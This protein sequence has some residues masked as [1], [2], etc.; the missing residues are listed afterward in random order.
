[1][2]ETFSNYVLLAPLSITGPSSSRQ[3]AAQLLMRQ[4]CEGLIPWAAVG[5]ADAGARGPLAQRMGLVAMEIRAAV[6]ERLLVNYE[7]R[8]LLISYKDEL[9]AVDQALA[10]AS[11]QVDLCLQQQDIMLQFDNPSDEQQCQLHGSY[12]QMKV[13]M[14]QRMM[15]QHRRAAVQQLLAKATALFAPYLGGERQRPNEQQLADLADHIIDEAA[16]EDGEEAAE[17]VAGAD[18]EAWAAELC[19]DTAPGLA[20][21][22]VTTGPGAAA[23]A[24]AAAAAAATPAAASPDSDQAGQP[25]IWGSDT[26]VCCLQLWFS[27][28]CLHTYAIDAHTLSHCESL[29]FYHTPFSS[30]ARDI[31]CILCNC[32]LVCTCNSYC[33]NSQ[34]VLECQKQLQRLVRWCGCQLHFCSLPD[35]RSVCLVMCFTHCVPSLLL[36]S[37]LNTPIWPRADCFVCCVVAAC[38]QAK[39][40]W[41]AS[42]AMLAEYNALQ[43]RFAAASSVALDRCVAGSELTLRHMATVF[44]EQMLNDEV[45]NVRLAVLQRANAQQVREGRGVKV[46]IYST[47]F[48]EKLRLDTQRAGQVDYAAVRRFTLPNAL[49]NAG[50]QEASVL[51]CRY[52]IAPCHL[53]LHWVLVVA[54][55]QERTFIYLDPLGVSSVWGKGGGGGVTAVC[56]LCWLLRCACFVVGLNVA[57]S[58]ST[59]L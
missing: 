6:H 14:G 21:C 46:H 36:L 25:V 56:M 42:P 37:L 34:Q 38:M 41:E 49:R 16:A 1:M 28:G 10:A 8:N 43:A 15:L 22:A 33:S 7:M 48:M 19:D 55:M 47:F 20:A 53:P 23:V 59:M 4:L 5:A 50:Q 31:V 51:D 30:T 3:A 9:A 24:P 45:L 57:Y 11:M 29:C 40:P 17:A 58:T 54:D 13:A 26:H 32:I 44:P 52:L 2:L 35:T 18:D 39:A 12:R 27:V